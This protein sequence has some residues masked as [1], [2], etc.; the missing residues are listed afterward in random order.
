MVK[1]SP[2]QIILV[3]K[4]QYNDRVRVRT[5]EELNHLYY[6]SRKEDD[7]ESPY[8][9]RHQQREILHDLEILTG[10]QN[11]I[12]DELAESGVSVKE[13]LAAYRENR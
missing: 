2:E 7:G 13:A 11:N 6:L 12:A 1:L 9:L 8:E 10:Y 4:W 3:R 5:I